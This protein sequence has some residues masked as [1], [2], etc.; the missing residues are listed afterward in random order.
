MDEGTAGR[1]SASR[2]TRSAPRT[3]RT[4]AGIALFGAIF[5]FDAA[6]EDRNDTTGDANPATGD[7]NPS[8][9]DA[10]PATGDANPASA[11]TTAADGER[12]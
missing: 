1:S 5:G 7:A 6:D 12:D 10:N 11:D 3:T 4:R 9:G 2:S 8:T